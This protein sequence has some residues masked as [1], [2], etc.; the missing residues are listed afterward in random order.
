LKDIPGAEGENKYILMISKSDFLPSKFIMPNGP[1]GTMSRTFDKLEFNYEFDNDIWTGN[2]LPSGY[3]KITFEQ[4]IK[5]MQSKLSSKSKDG[6]DTI[7]NQ[8]IEKWKIPDLH[9][10]E[11]VDF[12][13]FRGNVVLLEFW[14]KGCA[15]CVK[16]VPQ[17]NSLLQKYKDENFI[18]YGIEYQENFT[19]ENLLEY[20]SEISINYP[21]LYKGKNIASAFEIRAAP[22]FIIINK[23]GKIVYLKSGF[24]QEEIEDIIKENL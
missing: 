10:N 4:Y 6:V 11:L 14:F 16:A 18:L 2:L 8:N 3:E 22:T 15:P 19:Q 12:S 23:K 24:N 9:S 20:A 1:T 13:E 17:L 5:R 21:I 7:E